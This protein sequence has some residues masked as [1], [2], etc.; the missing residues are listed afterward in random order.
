MYI[1][2]YLSNYRDKNIYSGL[3]FLLTRENVQSF[4]NEKHYLESM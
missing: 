3:S 4:F 2:L 1:Y